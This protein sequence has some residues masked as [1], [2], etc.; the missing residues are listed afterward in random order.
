MQHKTESRHSVRAS[1]SVCHR[2]IEAALK[3]RPLEASAEPHTTQAHA[4][5]GGSEQSGTTWW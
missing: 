5:A 4:D 2:S 3:T 1:T